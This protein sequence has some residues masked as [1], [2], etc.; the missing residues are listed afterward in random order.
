[1]AEPK[2]MVLNG[3]FVNTQLNHLETV[4]LARCQLEKQSLLRVLFHYPLQLPQR[5][6]A[7]AEIKTPHAHPGAITVF[8]L[9]LSLE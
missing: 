6:T 1:M 5:G 9:F 8:F 2:L 3:G 7:D 4:V